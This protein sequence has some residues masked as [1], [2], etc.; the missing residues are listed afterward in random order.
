MENLRGFRVARIEIRNSPNLGRAIHSTARPKR[1]ALRRAAGARE[2]RTRLAAVLG[3][4]RHAEVEAR[5]LE[6]DVPFP[7][8]RA[9][10]GAGRGA[11]SPPG[12]QRP[13]RA[14]A[15]QRRRVQTRA[16]ALR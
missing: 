13:K 1:R 6:P 16:V 5:G 14:S 10:G 12:S 3:E 4:A 11:G 9:A 7:A 8:G 2:G 15:A